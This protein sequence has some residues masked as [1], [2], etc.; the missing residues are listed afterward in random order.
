M[1]TF[2]ITGE[3]FI[4][5]VFSD[6]NIIDESGPWESFEAAESWATAYTNKLND[7]LIS[8]ELPT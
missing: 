8:P 5:K 3:T 2:E 4:C 7:G 6:Q 1:Y